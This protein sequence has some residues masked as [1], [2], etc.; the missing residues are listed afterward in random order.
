VQD[1]LHAM[2]FQRIRDPLHNIIEF[3]DNVFERQMWQVMQ[4]QPFQRLRRIK[5]L[6]FSE[7]VYP[8][9][10]HTRFAHSVGVFHTARML[11]KIVEK[12]LGT[13]YDPRRA[14]V[15]LAA[16]LLHDVGH[17]PF[18]HS[19]EDVGNRL[20]LK[21]ANHE[22]VSDA[23]IRDGEIVNSLKGM[24][25]GFTVDVADLIG[26][27]GRPDIYGAVVSSQFDADRLDYMRRDRLMTGTH[28]GAID[29]E[30]LLSNLQIG[31]ATVGVD[32]EPVDSVATFV[33][34]PKAIYAA[35]TYVL[36]LFQLYPTVYFH[37]ATRG[38][39]KVF[40]ELIFQI[41]MLTRDNSVSQTGLSDTH[42]LIVFA[43]DP[44][45]IANVLAL[46]DTVVMGS[47]SMLEH[48]PD[49][50][51]AHLATHLRC[52]SLYRCIDIREQIK[53]QIASDQ[54]WSKF[55]ATIERAFE[56]ISTENFRVLNDSKVKA[57]VK[58]TIQDRIDHDR[59]DRACNHAFQALKVADKLHTKRPSI[60][61]DEA[62]RRPYKPM[63]ESKGPL[64]QILIRSQSDALLDVATVSRVIAAI[65]DFKLLRAYVDR[66]DKTAEALVNEAIKEG[67][68]YAMA[69]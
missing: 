53:Q 20:G 31:E 28:H 23:L 24:G 6:G 56:Q 26:H 43:R 46:D 37:K 15:A 34:G 68:T 59:L 17:G 49:S 61:L 1:K 38:A 27:A 65:H 60:L 5:Q 42:P 44:E 19:F 2:S 45:N 39:E 29:F 8:G 12:T 36:G 11:M 13:K 54:D 66:D 58:I 50:C 48:A 63:Q 40:S 3:E 57:A 10:T 35:E 64:E 32:E 69:S 47:L 16:S 52:R 62:K 14:E 7:L 55:D 25:S 51:V 41:V 67:V 18:S 22:K 21:L 33:L 9:A 4:T 30:W